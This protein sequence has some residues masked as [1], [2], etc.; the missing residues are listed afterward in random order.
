MYCPVEEM[1]TYQVLFVR[2]EL[3]HEVPEFVE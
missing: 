1:A 2:P 3:V